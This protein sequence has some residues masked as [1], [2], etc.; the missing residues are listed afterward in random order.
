MSSF[1]IGL[2]IG[3]SHITAALVRVNDSSNATN[4]S[5]AND[6]LCTRPYATHVNDDPR[7]IVSSWIAC[8]HDL[9]EE[10]VSK[11]DETDA[12][13]GMACGIPGPM[14]YRQGICHIQSSTFNK[15]DRC[16]GL[17]LRLTLENALA[18][19]VD[20][21]RTTL[22]SARHVPAASND[23]TTRVDDQRV[24]LASLSFVSN[25]DVDVRTYDR[26]VVQQ[27]IDFCGSFDNIDEEHDQSSTETN[28]ISQSVP[29]SRPSTA[30]VERA[31]NLW[32]SI[33][34]LSHRPIYFYND[35]TCFA[36]GEAI[37]PYH[38]KFTRILAVTLGTGF[39]ST[40]LDGERVIVRGADV[41]PGGM[42]WNVPYDDQLLADE[43][44]STRGLLR[45][46]E[47]TVREQCANGRTSTDVDID[48]ANERERTCDRCECSSVRFCRSSGQVRSSTVINW[49]GK[50][51]KA[52]S[53]LNEHSRSSLNISPCFSFR[54]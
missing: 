46:Y 31:T 38:R 40:F 32:S 39:G 11:S 16:Y 47:R 8:I 36:I 48:K 7:S 14:D 15:F 45:I 49:L 3:G 33:E 25:V 1:V 50:R 29:C 12:I 26:S 21:W 18:N 17:N 34:H 24:S 43:W 20:D 5:I 44:F 6:I 23:G 30:T 51:P 35:A 22:S 54:T 2:D 27:T 52:M 13:V 10:F 28:V 37:G 9:L 53:T 19:V 4:L 41:P 42:L